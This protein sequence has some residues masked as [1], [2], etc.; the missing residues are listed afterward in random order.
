MDS[1]RHQR[2]GWK[3]SLD[4]AVLIIGLVVTFFSWQFIDRVLKSQQTFKEEG[5]VDEIAQWTK[6]HLDDYSKMLSGVNGL[7]N[8]RVDVSRSEFDQYLKGAQIDEHY[9]GIYAFSYVTNVSDANALL[10]L[11]NLEDEIGDIDTVSLEL[12][13]S[14][15]HYIV[16]YLYLVK[17]GLPPASY[18]YDLKLDEDRASALEQA[19]DTGK[20]VASK[21][22]IL[23]GPDKPGFILT[24]PIYKQGME[25]STIDQRREAIQGWVNVAFQYDYLFDGILTRKQLENYDVHIFDEN[26]IIYDSLGEHD[27]AGR[28][29]VATK[30][31]VLGDKQWKMEFFS[32]TSEVA[33]FEKDL[34]GIVF[35]TGVFASL[36]LFSLMYTISSSTVRAENLVREMT[37]NLQLMKLAVDSSYSHVIITDNDGKITYAN[38]SVERITGYSQA[39]MIGKTPRLW[40]GLMDKQFYQ[41]MWH[42]IKDLGQ[43]FT[44]EVRNRRKNGQEYI[45]SITISPV[46]DDKNQLKG[47][48][49]VEEDVSDRKKYESNLEQQK[50]ELE[51]TNKLMVGRE[52]KMAELKKENE[53][54]KGGEKV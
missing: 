19:R 52:L 12:A 25:I 47:Y 9:K 41:D 13:E 38:K 36:L 54:L 45:A 32:N 3:N 50:A 20:H 5:V 11:D 53:R 31:V 30:S 14:S 7:F 39:E 49:G 27:D 23:R 37:G 10:F 34:P 35:V 15:E 16:D 51:R 42:T 43:A 22:V 17:Q 40:G 8:A 26:T 48:V 18:G 4:L 28:H 46:K 2:Q 24:S 33:N 29:P 1:A 44:G 6:F 21:T